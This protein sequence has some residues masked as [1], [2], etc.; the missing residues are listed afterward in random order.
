M[1]QRLGRRAR[2][3]LVANLLLSSACSQMG[4]GDY[5]WIGGGRSLP[6]SKGALRVRWRKELTPSE[7]GRYRPIENSVAAIDAKRERLYVGAASGRLYALGFNGA[8]LYH[9]ELHEPI[10]SEPALD[11]DKDELFVA[12]ERNQ[13]YAL[14]PS[15]GKIL[16]KVNSS[17]NLRR[18]PLLFKDALY[19]I[20][21]DDGV[22]ALSRADGSMLWSYHREHSEGFLVAGHSGLTLSSDGTLYAAFNDG[23]I[24]ALDALDGKPK[25]ERDTAADVPEAEP[26]RPRYID[27][28]ATPQ[29]IGDVVYAASF[30]GGLYCLDA[31]NGSVLWREAEWTGITGLA[32]GPGGSLI[33]VSADRGVARFDPASR[34]AVWVKSLERGAF[35][36]PQLAGELVLIGDSRGSLVALYTETGEEVGRIDSGHGFAARAVV[37]DRRGFV[38]SNGGV[39]LALELVTHSAPS[40]PTSVERIELRRQER[41]EARQKAAAQKA[42]AQKAAAQKAAAQQPP[43]K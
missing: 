2:C 21:E 40:H 26:G 38:V 14:R 24:V 16:W 13:L 36:V 1:S 32:E 28:D 34:S 22:D 6:E 17:A 25:W 3:L 19:V 33:M 9:F 8:P 31:H 37:E 18:K 15:T 29:R 35:G 10:E 12:N 5:S 30:G 20:S 42:A 41:Q 39:L 23:T 43:Q 7:R 11:P 4:H 27:A